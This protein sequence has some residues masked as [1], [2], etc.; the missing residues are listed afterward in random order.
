MREE[1]VTCDICGAGVPLS[2]WVYLPFR[3]SYVSYELTI[4]IDLCSMEC[5]HK[6]FI[7][8][9]HYMGRIGYEPC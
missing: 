6:F 3:K 1:F 8:Y 9:R 7:Y 5:E 4:K 2:T